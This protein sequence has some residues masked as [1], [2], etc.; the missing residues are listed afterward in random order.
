MKLNRSGFVKKEDMEQIGRLPNGNAHP[1]RK[2]LRTMEVGQVLHVHRMDWN[3]T[4]KTPQ[5]IVNQM[6]SEGD[7]RFQCSVAADDSGWF[8]ERLQ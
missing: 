8:I 3:W 5:V 7:K 6:H 4:A 2:M 1:V